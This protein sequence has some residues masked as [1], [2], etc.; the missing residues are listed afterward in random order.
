[1]KYAAWRVSFQDSE[2]AARKAFDSWQSER[3]E[4][5]LQQQKEADLFKEN[6]RLKLV[7]SYIQERCANGAMPDVLL[8]EIKRGMA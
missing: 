7:I 3:K 2:R 8:T 4:R 5:V 1:M 6:E